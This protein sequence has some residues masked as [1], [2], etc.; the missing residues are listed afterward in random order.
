MSHL[1]ARIMEWAEALSEGAPIRQNALLHLGSPPAIRQSLSRLVRRGLLMRICRGVYMRTIE[2]P[3]GRR[4][5]YEHEAIRALATLWGET[6]APNGGAAANIL[7][8]STQNVVTS[9]YWTSGPNRQLAYGKRPIIL[10]HVP[11]WQLG[12][13]DRPA[14]MLLRAL[15]WL[16]PAFPQE[17]EEALETVVPGL[18]VRDREEFASLQGVMPAWLARPV[19]MRLAHE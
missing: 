6:I 1:P 14:G 15:A 17:I 3:Y 9:V 18:S 4:S 11:H 2:T 5:P 12:A 13:A 16:G 10:R 8:L 7:R 19:S